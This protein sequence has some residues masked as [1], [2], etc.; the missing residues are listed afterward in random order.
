MQV[1]NK[2]YG[3]PVAT[4]VEKYNNSELGNVPEKQRL[5]SPRLY[6]TSG[7]TGTSEGLT[8]HRSLTNVS[9]PSIKHKSLTKRV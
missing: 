4:T 9:F 6:E 8:I 2:H 1:F 7:I 3:M 5:E